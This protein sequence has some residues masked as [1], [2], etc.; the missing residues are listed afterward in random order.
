VKTGRFS[1]GNYSGGITFAG[2][3]EKRIQ[4]VEGSRVQGIINW[5]EV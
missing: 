5:R 2:I 4:G 3:K 1:S